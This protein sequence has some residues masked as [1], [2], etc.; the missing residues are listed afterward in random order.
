MCTDRSHLCAFKP[1][2]IAAGLI[3]R[4]G[5]V[6]FLS[7][8]AFDVLT[9]LWFRR[10]PCFLSDVIPA[11]NSSD[12]NLDAIWM[13]AAVRPSPSARTCSTLRWAALTKRTTSLLFIDAKFAA[14]LF[15]KCAFV[16]GPDQCPEVALFEPAIEFAIGRPEGASADRSLSQGLYA[17]RLRPP[18]AVFFAPSRSA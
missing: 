3:C 11:L 16:R 6:I 4:R 10:Q 13:I 2:G 15:N 17:R 18:T 8:R 7:P 5:G 14:C 9:D 12:Q 1:S